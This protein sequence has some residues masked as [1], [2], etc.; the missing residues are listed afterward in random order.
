MGEWYEQVGFLLLAFLAVLPAAPAIHYAQ[1]TLRP[2]PALPR[3]RAA[4]RLLFFAGVAAVIYMI[5][6]IDAF[7]IEPNWPR[8]RTLTLE[9]DIREPIEILHLSDLHIE[10]DFPRREQWLL[11]T[12]AKL[13][14]D[15]ILI[16]GDIHQMDNYDAQSVGRVLNRIRA[17]LGVYACQG[18]DSLS[19]LREAAPHLRMLVNEA[20]ELERGADR[21]GLAGL[22]ATG[23]RE[24][25][26]AALDETAFSIAIHHTPDLADEAAA[27]GADLYL[28]GHTHGG[29]VR[30]PFWGAI[31]TNCRSGKKYEGGVYRNGITTIHTSRGLGLEPRPAPQARFLCR[32]EITRVFVQ[33][34]A[35]AS[36]P[37]SPPATE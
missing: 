5:V 20:V 16:T 27:C 6:C 14:P 33:P 15:L 30:I 11:E 17:P 24:P 18:Y 7:L 3:R 28:C 35:T 26:Y 1:R 22:A 13:S 9:A 23:K 31:I 25:V 2:V 10:P 36:P 8:V 32:P 19:L 4:T 21:I 29:Q 37:L 34:R 12:I